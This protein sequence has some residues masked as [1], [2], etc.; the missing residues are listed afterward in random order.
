M[1]EKPE[2]AQASPRSTLVRWAHTST[3]RIQKV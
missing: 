3:L 1:S 2:M